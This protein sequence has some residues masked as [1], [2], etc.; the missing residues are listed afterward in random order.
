MEY[1]YFATGPKHWLDLHVTHMQCQPFFIP[2]IAP[3]GQNFQQAMMGILEP[4]VL[5]RYIVPEAGMP[6]VVNTLG[7]KKKNQGWG[8]SAAGMA[9]RKTLGLKEI[10]DYPETAAK[11]NVSL[12]HINLIPLGIKDDGPDRL[13]YPTGVKQEPI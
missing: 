8:L 11:L 3:N 4:V 2:G 10:P 13:M 7:N 12:D 6:L 1:W 5:F 9:L